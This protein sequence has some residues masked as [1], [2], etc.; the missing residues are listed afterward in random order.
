[1]TTEPF[2]MEREIAAIRERMGSRSPGIFQSPTSD[3][4]MASAVRGFG[5]K[6]F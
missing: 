6:I 5:S 1:M 4:S 3:V 2:D